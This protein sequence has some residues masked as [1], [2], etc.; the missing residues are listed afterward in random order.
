[1]DRS[2]GSHIPRD[3]PP[4][5]ADRYPSMIDNYGLDSVSES[6][7]TSVL[8]ALL[9]VSTNANGSVGVVVIGAIHL[10]DSLERDE[11]NRTTEHD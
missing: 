1:M 10:S 8:I 6:L 7:L 5:N 4:E 3:T 11:P 2:P 9:V